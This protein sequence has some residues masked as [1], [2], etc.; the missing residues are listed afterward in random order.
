MWRGESGLAVWRGE[1]GLAVW[2][3]ESG[4]AVKHPDRP[5]DCAERAGMVAVDVHMRLVEMVE[6]RAQTAER[7]CVRL[8]PGFLPVGS[9][10][11]H[12]LTHIHT[13]SHTHAHTHSHTHT[14]THTLTHTH[15]YTHTNIHAH[16]HKH[17]HGRTRTDARRD[18]RICAHLCRTRELE[19]DVL[20]LQGQVRMAKGLRYLTQ[21][22]ADVADILGQLDRCLATA[23]RC[24][25]LMCDAALV[26]H[27]Y[28][29]TYTHTH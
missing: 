27:I 21:D 9:Q 13:H 1:S 5:V 23:T 7:R 14:H 19:T 25:A 2:R 29:C 28:I 3:G 10:H 11:A 4:L 16:T 22:D 18:I 26:K 8:A 12:S 17:T 24:V 15:S 20:A 6:Q